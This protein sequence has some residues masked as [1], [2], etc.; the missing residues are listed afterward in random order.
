MSKLYS[1]CCEKKDRDNNILKTENSRMEPDSN[2]IPSGC[3]PLTLPP[4]YGGEL[5]MPQKS[6][7]FKAMPLIHGHLYR[8]GT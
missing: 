1:I 3:T 6:L 4:R 8:L 2:W 7:L 5:P